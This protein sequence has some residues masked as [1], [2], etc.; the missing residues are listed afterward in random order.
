MPNGVKAVDP[1][2]V[3]GIIRS[4]YGVI[5]PWLK[6]EAAKSQTPI[7]DWMLTLLDNL[8]GVTG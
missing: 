6:E 2:L 1:G 7:D 3:I 5:R 4:I 8:L